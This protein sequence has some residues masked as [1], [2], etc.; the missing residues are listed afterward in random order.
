M[1]KT[2]ENVAVALPRIGIVRKGAPKPEGKPGKDLEYFRFITPH[3]AVQAAWNAAIG[4]R[5]T[6]I[7]GFL[8][9]ADPNECL[10]Q[11]DELWAGSR[12]LWRGDGERLHIEL[13]GDHYVSYA[14]GEGPMQPAPAK[15][16]MGKNVVSRVSRLRLIMP[17]LRIAGIVE[18]L[19]TSPIDADELWSNLGWIRT[20]VATLQGAPVTV[21]RSP[22]NFQIPKPNG[23]E[24][25]MKVVKHMLGMMLD[26]TFMDQLLPKPALPERTMMALPVSIGREAELEVVLPGDDDDDEAVWEEASPDTLDTFLEQAKVRPGVEAV[27]F[28]ADRLRSWV[29]YVTDGSYQ[30]RHADLLF[31]VLDAY[32]SVVEVDQNHTRPRAEQAKSNYRGKVQAR[33]AEE[34][35]FLSPSGEVIQVPPIIDDGTVA[36]DAVAEGREAASAEEPLFDGGNG[37]ALDSAEAEMRRHAL[38]I[39]NATG[40]PNG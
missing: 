28:A 24:G 1:I 38:A 10:A 15:A 11:W 8:P 22:R 14:D 25:T 30:V 36:G 9:Y 4:E 16:R 37:S 23:G 32:C 7:S 2:F 29:N 31:E 40:Y 12:M 20:V 35:Q 34:G 39:M 17:Q 5:P 18:V 6:S 19:S 3:A 26:Q 33:M 27:T 13:K 21:F